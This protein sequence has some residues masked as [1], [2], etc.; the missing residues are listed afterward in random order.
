MVLPSGSAQAATCTTADDHDGVAYFWYPGATTT[1]AAG[2]EAPLQL[3]KEGTV[4]SGSPY[5]F[6]ATFIAIVPNGTLNIIQIG[7][8]HQ[9]DA[10]TGTDRYCKWWA[11]GIGSINLFQ[12]GLGSDDYF[13]F[14]IAQPAG[15]GQ[16]QIEVCGKA[17]HYA[18]GCTVMGSQN[19]T[20]VWADTAG[21]TW[22]ENSDGKTCLDRGMGTSANPA[23]LGDSA[24]S[25]KFMGTSGYT[26]H[27]VSPVE[28]YPG[29][30]P[31]CS[32]YHM[33]YNTD[34]GTGDLQAF[35]PYDDRN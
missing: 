17:L 35:L 15:G 32:H 6:S 13:Y 10:G 2:M 14:R 33:P 31:T 12:C 30:P 3:R 23:N 20:G 34:S 8:I 16:F 5:G 22:Y 4:C 28:L 11:K 19:D 18:D 21:F 9:W 27:T 1:V 7:L 24:D 26:F 25:V 29:D